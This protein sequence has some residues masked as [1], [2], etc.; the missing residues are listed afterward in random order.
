MSDFFQDGSMATLHRLGP[1]D[2][3]R[4]ERE[5]VD[6]SRAKPIALVLPCHVNDL[7]AP[8]LRHIVDELRH[9]PYVHQIVVGIDG[10]TE[11]DWQRARELFATLPQSPVLLWNDGPRMQELI[12]RLAAADLDPG[13][14]GKGRNLWLAFGYVLASQQAGMV[15]T[16][17][18]DILTYNREML[19]RLCYP[20]AHPHLGFDF[21]KGFSARFTDRLNGRVMRLLFT[22]LVRS[23][24]SI[25]G[26]QPFLTFLDSFRYPLSG[27]TSLDLDVVRRSRVPCDWGVEVGV[28]AEV[29]RVCAPKAICQVDM[30]DC[31]DHKHQEIS[32]NDASKGLNKMGGDVVKCVFRTLAGQGVKLD[33]G[34]F[35][36]LL[37]AYVR[38]AEDTMRFSAADAEING[39][40]YSRHDEETVVQAFIQSIRRAAADYLDNPLGE[41]M[42]PDWDRV[43]GALP[44][45]LPALH[46]AVAADN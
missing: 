6:F 14:S 4:L 34:T 3:D 2:V 1:P 11:S 35:D 16:H 21:C 12:R 27:E 44:D 22:P 39:L 24:Q 42:I 13:T 33:R 37:T 31:Y 20:V 26:E 17:D 46:A 8:A 23:L 7:D 36:T 38:K 10:A 19:A 43:E 45:F 18:C 9:V 28:L 41:P 15:A 30:A 29:F 32:L 5:L 25:L 40:R